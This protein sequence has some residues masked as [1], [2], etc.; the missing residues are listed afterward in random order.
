MEQKNEGGQA[1]HFLLP[2]AG[3]FDDEENLYRVVMTMISFGN[4]RTVDALLVN[5]LM[6]NDSIS[7]AVFSNPKSP[8]DP[9]TKDI[10]LMHL[11][12]QEGLFRSAK[13]LN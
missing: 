2:K 7:K 13:Y 3:T 10:T 8:D 4:A 9:H 1:E 11:C 12:C 6:A 5:K